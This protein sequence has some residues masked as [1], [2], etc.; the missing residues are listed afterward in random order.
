MEWKKYSR[1]GVIEMRPYIEGEDLTGISVS[2]EDFPPKLGG[3]IARDPKKTG[4]RWYVRQS[5]FEKHYGEV[6]S[7]K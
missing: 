7:G 2:P 1:V 3:M 4:D 6:S 5:Y